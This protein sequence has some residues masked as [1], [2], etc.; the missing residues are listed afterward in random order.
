MIA[1]TATRVDIITQTTIA[2]TV[3]IFF[4]PSGTAPVASARPVTAA[5]RVALPTVR[6][7]HGFPMRPVTLTASLARRRTMTRR[8]PM[9]RRGALTR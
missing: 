9:T 5:R 8:R 3:A 1:T 2:M 6:A 7:P 4:T